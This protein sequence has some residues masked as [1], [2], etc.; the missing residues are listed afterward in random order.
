MSVLGQSGRRP[1]E[2]DNMAGRLLPSERKV[3]AILRVNQGPF[4]VG[5]CIY[6]ETGSVPIC[7]SLTGSIMLS[8]F[9][10]L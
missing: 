2:A 4:L 10:S 1:S 8:T 5:E 3:V 6:S 9:R 7:G